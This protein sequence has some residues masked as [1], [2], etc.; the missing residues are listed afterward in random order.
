MAKRKVSMSI[1]QVVLVAALIGMNANSNP[2]ADFTLTVSPTSVTVQRGSNGG[3]LITLTTK[4]YCGT[5]NLVANVSPNQRYAPTLQIRNYDVYICTDPGF[6]ART[7][8]LTIGTT[9]KTPT[10]T[11]TITITAKAIT[12]S[13]VT[14]TATVTLTVT[15]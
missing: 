8:P 12:G 5:V 13:S 3:S 4:G 11:Y 6:E 1:K 2:S 7:T 15:P 14:H 10:G 9:S